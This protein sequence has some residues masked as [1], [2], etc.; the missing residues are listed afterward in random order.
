MEKPKSKFLQLFPYLL[1]WHGFLLIVSSSYLLA[2]IF[3][4]KGSLY[5][6]MLIGTSNRLFDLIYWSGWL[7][8]LAF[9]I[10]S[11]RRRDLFSSYANKSL[12]FI[13]FTNLIFLYPVYRIPL[14]YLAPPSFFYSLF[15]ENFIR[16][17]AFP[18]FSFSTFYSILH[19]SKKEISFQFKSKYMFAYFFIAVVTFLLLQG[20]PFP[21]LEDE[22]AYFFQSLIFDKGQIVFQMQK[23]TGITWERFSEIVQLPYI[24]FNEGVIYSAH[25]HGTSFLFTLFGKIHIKPYTGVILLSLSFI[26]YYLLAKKLFK[27]NKNG[28]YLSYLLFI[29]SPLLI[30]LSSTYMSHIP[31]LFFLVLMTYGRILIDTRSRK[32]LS[33]SLLFLCLGIF[34]SIWVRPQSAFPAI[35]ALFLFDSYRL[36]LKK[37]ADK[38]IFLYIVFYSIVLVVSYSSLKLYS[39]N[40]PAKNI[41]LTSSFMGNFFESGCQSIGIGEKTGCFAT[42]GTLGHSPL[43]LLFNSLDLISTLSSEHSI[44]GIPLMP[45]FLFL[46]PIGYARMKKGKFDLL[47]FGIFSMNLGIFSLYWHNG[48]ESYKGRYLADSIFSFYLLLGI[49][50]GIFFKKHLREKI[51]KH[52]LAFA[53]S[54]FFLI[55]SAYSILF[56]IRGHYLNREYVPYTSLDSFTKDH[57]RNSI[58]A[59]AN[60]LNVPNELFIEKY[61]V[62]RERNKQDKA[63]FTKKQILST[64]NRG[65]VTLAAIATEM[66]DFGYLRDSFG[67]VLLTEIASDEIEIFGKQINVSNC[68]VIP[69]FEE[70]QMKNDKKKLITFWESKLGKFKDCRIKE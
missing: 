56:G 33:F 47:L 61:T 38:R 27:T 5:F 3:S 1:P 17:I 59:S 18:I 29:G 68:Y 55:G 46:F 34:G 19:F 4:S 70:F 50:G 32:Q 66:D 21:K 20:R 57:P 63:T 31:A 39:D 26:V 69:F 8:L 12:F 43:K 35:F 10:L 53:I 62:P 65:N 42:Y 51:K 52:N 67:N 49:W 58:L 45:I 40:L 2:N 14:D 64:Y 6:P 36:I 23:P 25:F 24:F 48:G 11:V 41:F 28:M 30:T 37:F 15:K 44:L 54:I 60:S 9:L 16:A 22:F 13:Y 7:Y